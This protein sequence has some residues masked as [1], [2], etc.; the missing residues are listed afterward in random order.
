V[1]FGLGGLLLFAAAMKAEQLPP[2]SSP[3]IPSAMWWLVV[4]E[5]G[6]AAW[7]LAGLLP[8]LT[9][10]LAFGCFSAFGVTAGMKLFWGEADCGCFGAVLLSPTAALAIDSTA[11]LLLISCKKPAGIARGG[12]RWL[13]LVIVA[14]VLLGGWLESSRALAP[15]IS[16]SRHVAA[17]WSPGMRFPLLPHLDMGSELGVGE[18]SLLLVRPGCHHCE[19]LCVRLMGDRLGGLPDELGSV[20]V[21][22]V[23][24][25]TADSRSACLAF[26][27][28]ARFTAS[29][30][31]PIA[32]PLLVRI[33]NG[34][35]VD[36]VQPDLMGAAT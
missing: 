33:S 26:P 18:W 11:V 24:P 13:A 25:P 21:L 1:R 9:W 6:F 27:R 7:L 19:A 4:L 20:V 10:W 12:R 36:V 35:I 8:Q 14:V 30:D 28:Q 3:W 15:I 2:I 32:T 31:L 16:R 22:F 34:L 29:H 5:F 17:N 23:V